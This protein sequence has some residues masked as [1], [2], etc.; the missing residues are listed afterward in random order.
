[1]TLQGCEA[2][3]VAF[4]IDFPQLYAAIIAT[5]GKDRAIRA[6]RECPGHPAMSPEGHQRFAI[7]QVPNANLPAKAADSQVVAVRTERH[8]GNTLNRLCEER[9]G[10][11][12]RR[13]I[14]IL[15]FYSLQI[16]LPHHNMGA[17]Y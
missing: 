4:S 15:C 7:R 12:G 9:I 5:T 14:G 8:R 13:K 2:V 1:M 6:E 10:D 16:S 3:S 17:I 11:V